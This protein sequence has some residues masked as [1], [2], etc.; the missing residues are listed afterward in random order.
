MNRVVDGHSGGYLARPMA[1]APDMAGR[2]SED[3]A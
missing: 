3:P 2:A 1:T